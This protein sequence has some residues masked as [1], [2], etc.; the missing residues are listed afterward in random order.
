MLI[1][2]ESGTTAEE[3]SPY[4]LY[5]NL[6]CRV[7]YNDNTHGLQIITNDSVEDVTLGS[8]D[9][10]VTANDF[11]YDG[12]FLDSIFKKAAASYNNVVDNLNQK[13]EK[14]KGTKAIDA[15]C[16]GSKATL[17]N[18]VFDKKDDS[19]WY[20]GSYVEENDLKLKNEDKNFIE[21]HARSHSLGLNTRGWMASR[22]IR[23]SDD[24]NFTVRIFTSSSWVDQTLCIVRSSDLLQGDGYTK[25]AGFSPVFL[26]SSDIQISSGSGS[27]EDPYVIE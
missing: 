22:F 27:S 16:V 14:Y 13:A 20:E 8:S 18:G 26:L 25:T 9:P 19:G 6:L 2:N 24:I 3:K 4:V 7:L 23:D 11:D 21:D 10:T 1:P 17:K 15:R 5:N 12:L